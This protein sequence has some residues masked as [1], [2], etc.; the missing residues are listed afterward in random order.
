MSGARPGI[1]TYVAPAATFGVFT[2]LEGVVPPAW[3]PAAYV[4]KAI[5]VTASLYFC[6]ST[7][8]DIVPSRRWLVS[9]V[10]LGLVV[11]AGWVGIEEM[12]AYPHLGSREAFDP[13]LADATIG[14]PI[15]L[16]VR[17]YGLVLMVPVMEELLWRSFVLRYATQVDFLAIPIGTF[18]PVA[19]GIT[20]AVSGFSHPEWVVGA[21]A[22]LAYCLW[23]ARTRSLFSTVVAHATT[24]AALGAYVLATHSWKY[25]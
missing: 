14:R 22:N 19:L 3:Y 10:V 17:L 18:S 8:A 1:V 2:A 4:V 24:N 15:F 25:W 23:L 20:V 12:I 16:A 6:R 7:L 9:S 21:L 13:A 5:A 11:F